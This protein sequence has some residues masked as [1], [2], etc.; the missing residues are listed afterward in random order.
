MWPPLMASVAV[1]V[2]ELVRV[3]ICEKIR[4]ESSANRSLF[5]S[6][7]VGRTA[8]AAVTRDTG[9]IA[10]A[11]ETPI[12]ACISTIRG[13]G[14]ASVCATWAVAATEIATAVWNNAVGGV[15]VGI[16]TE[17]QQREQNHHQLMNH[18]LNRRTS[19]Y[20]TDAINC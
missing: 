12:T 8:L 11:A 6:Q 9:V 16:L 18:L 4:I 7:R 17:H 14:P 5:V 15:H 13:Q 19:S 1:V 2:V 3:G 20:V 10:V